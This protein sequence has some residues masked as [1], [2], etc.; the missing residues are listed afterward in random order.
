MWIEKLNN[1]KYAARELY[2]DPFTG[3]R[4]KVSVTIEN[5]SPRARKEAKELLHDK[6]AWIMAEPERIAEA[7]R[8]AEETRRTLTLKSLRERYKAD[9]KAGGIEENTIRRNYITVGSMIDLLGEETPVNTLTA[10]MIKTAL[11]KSNVKGSTKN[12]YL[13]RFKAMMRWAYQNDLVES[14]EYLQKIR[15]FK[16][17]TAREK[18]QEKFLE[19]DAVKILLDGMDVLR[20][21][22]LTRFLILSGLRI[23]E[24]IALN[25][26]DVTDEM[27]IVNKTVDVNSG[28][29]KQ[30]TKTQAGMREVD[31]Q[32]ELLEVIREIR[33]F[34]LTDMMLKG[35][36]SEIFLP[37][38]DGSYIHYYAFRKYLAQKS[39]EILNHEITPHALRH[40][41]VS[42]LSEKG[43][44]L[45]AISRRVGH[46]NSKI[47]RDIYL[48]ITEN[49]KKKDRNLI[50]DIRM[51]S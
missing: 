2:N 47:T 3:K 5:K 12:N 25:R 10:P 9:Q 29:L 36:R 26:S 15:P 27:I 30:R 23:G 40:T 19:G 46:D 13:L 41:H 6:I 4:S 16:D 21:K 43:Y 20:W 8:K 45:E 31:V 11:L 37:G 24:A 35:Y 28:E 22:L 33:R 38:F 50:M 51:L 32:P 42:L 48:H 39:K 34:T 14:V 18:L 1:G 7:E 17:D 44:P 49:Q